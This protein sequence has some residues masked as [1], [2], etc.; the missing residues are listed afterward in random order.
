[1]QQKAGPILVVLLIIASFLVGSMWT[2]IQYLEGRGGGGSQQAVVNPTGAVG[3][4]ANQPT[5]SPFSIAKL[6]AYAKGLG[7][8][9][10]KFDS[11][12]D[13]KK[14]DKVISDDIS[15]GSSI[16]VAGT[17]A[18]FINGKYLSGAQ[19]L[20]AF[21]E[22]IDKELNGTGEATTSAYSVTLQNM[23][24]QQA[25]NPN[26]VEV[27]INNNDP[28]RGGKSA[29]VTIVEFSDFECP[30][31]ARVFPTM[32]TLEQTYKDKIRLVFKQYPLQFH[33]YASGA[34]NAA[35]CANEQGKFWEY[36]DKLFTVPR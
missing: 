28:V 32:Q 5:E 17:P 12:L 31:C 36:H 3:Q 26:P 35:L 18:F 1:M 9:S 10:N 34:A 30:F 21:K 16:G 15:Y 11:C 13:S 4:Q 25:F 22:I 27:K 29:R 6:K 8:D 19:P 2:K 7:L 24:R 14:F 23:A 33:Q 20:E